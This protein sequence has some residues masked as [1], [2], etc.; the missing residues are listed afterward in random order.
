MTKIMGSVVHSRK[1]YICVMQLHGDVS[2]DRLREVVKE[3]TGLI[4]QRP[5]VRSN[6]KRALR[7]RNIYSMELL[8]AR[9]R[10]A[11]LRVES[12][13]GTYMRK[14]CW[15]MGLVLGIGA[16]MRELRRVKT[17]PFDEDHGLVT[18]QQLSEAVYR[19]KVEGKCDY[20][21]NVVMPGEFAVCELPKVVLR[22]SAVESVVNGALLAVPGI[23]LLTSDVK[24]GSQVAMMTLKGELVGL[25]EAA[26]GADEIMRSEK[27]I[28]VK[29]KRIVMPRGVY[30]RM[31][32]SGKA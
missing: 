8:E 27:G 11:L 32:K 7:V 4:Y 16:H 1:V 14:L 13:P 6:V 25:G 10:L 29:P 12:D 19:F 15:D 23:S 20:L 31:W 24:A 28:A 30:P 5:P 9:G 26:M 22:D 3:F 17:G 2:K 21:R 18:L